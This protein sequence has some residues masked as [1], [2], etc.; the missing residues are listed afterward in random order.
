MGL[1][2]GTEPLPQTLR[3]A[4]FE[5]RLVGGLC[6]SLRATPDEVFG[7]LTQVMGGSAATLRVVEVMTRPTL[8]MQVEHQHQVLNWALTDIESLIEHLNT[9]F[10]DEPQVKLLVVLGEWEDMLQV[11]ALQDDCLAAL[12]STSLLDGAH[13][14]AWLRNH[15]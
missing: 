3:R 15:F 14:L 13:N 1:V 9:H 2:R 5:G 6:L 11:W 10:L 8:H 4:C 12:V 7:P